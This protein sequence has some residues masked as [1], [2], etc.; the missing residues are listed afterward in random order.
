[1]KKEKKKWIFKYSLYYNEIGIWTQTKILI[2][3]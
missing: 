1:M 2:D 3:L